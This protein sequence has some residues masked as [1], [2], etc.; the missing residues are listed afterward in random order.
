MMNFAKYFRISVTKNCNLN[1]YYCHREGNFT[2][3]NVEL[4]AD[5]FAF[6]CSA[7][8]Q[9]GFKKFKLTGGEPTVREDICEIIE[10]LSALNLPDLS[11]ITNGTRLADISAELW[12]AGLR[13]LNVSLN[14]LNPERFKVIQRG[15]NFSKNKSADSNSA[16]KYSKTLQKILRGIEVARQTGFKNMKLNF[17]YS[18]DESLQ[19]LKDL[20]IFSAEHDCILVLL[21]VI[22]KNF[23][24]TLDYLYD[25]IKS[26]GIIREEIITDSE[27]IRKRLVY[28]KNSGKVL[29]RVDELA[30]CK[31]YIFC[32]KCLQKKICREGIFPVRL[33]ADGVIIPCMASQ[34]NRL[35]VFDFIKCRDRENLISAFEKVKRW[36]DV[37][38]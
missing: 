2:N 36:Q 4:T 28:L 14:T 9:S 15:E 24:C 20:I 32:E 10:K 22:E 19:D 38:K 26:F 12:Q 34:E 31:P 35:N 16:E 29:L 37:K 30:N 7:A 13:R 23:Y 8:L 33:S 6:V 18:T 27:G 3:S 25:L 1:C 21:P 5:D 17:V 11:M